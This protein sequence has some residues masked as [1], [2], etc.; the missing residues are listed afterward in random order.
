MFIASS[1]EGLG[2]AYAVQQS[3]EYDVEGTV[4]SQG[5]FTP[6]TYPIEDILEEL[7]KSDFGMFVFSPDDVLIIREESKKAVRDNVVFELGMFIGRLGRKRNFILT[8]RGVEDLRL[9]TD[10]SGLSPLTFDPNRSDGKLIA[11]LGPACNQARETMKRMGSVASTVEQVV[12]DLDEK[13]LAVMAAFGGGHFSRPDNKQFEG[14]IFDQGVAKLK[15]LKCLRFEVSGDGKLYAYHWTELGKAVIQKYGYDKKAVPPVVPKEAEVR[16]VIGGAV[17]EEAKTL[18]VAMSQDPDG[19]LL[20]VETFEGFHV[21]ANDET[22]GSGGDARVEALWKSALDE[23]LGHGLIRR[24]GEDVYTL[25][26]KGYKA[27]DVIRK[28]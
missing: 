5:V 11:A 9:P 1:K 19:T 27:A 12:A 4:W 26:P 10:L 8:P 17:S 14:H 15:S 23:L 20:V 28:K 6:S 22:F 25:T 24:E 18:V 3:L 16:S 2:V 21:Q 7:D 13:C